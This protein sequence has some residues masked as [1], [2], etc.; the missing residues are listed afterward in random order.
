MKINSSHS[1]A[2]VIKYDLHLKHGLYNIQYS[3]CADKDFII[4]C[5]LN[6]CKIKYLNTVFGI[7]NHIGLSSINK[8]KNYEETK[9]IFIDNYPIFFKIYF[10]VIIFLKK[11]NRL[12]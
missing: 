5:I 11:I 10:V 6:K 1:V 2:T 8:F 3:I 12:T 9:K 7:Y 4:K